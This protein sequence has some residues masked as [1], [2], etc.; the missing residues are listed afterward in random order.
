MPTTFKFINHACFTLTH[1]NHTIIFDPYLEGSTQDINDL[2]VEYIFVSHGHFDHLGSAIELAKN[3]DATIIST[4]EVCGVA[5]EAGAKAHAMHL[6]GTHEFP[7]GKVRLTLAF[8]GSGVPGGHAC[9]FIVD[10]YGTKLYFAGDTALFG[11]MQLLQRLDTFD[12]A[13]LP[14]GDNFT[15]GPKDAAIAAEFLQASYV[16]PIHYNTWPLI[17]QDPVKFKEDVEAHTKSKVL[18]VEPGA[19]IDRRTHV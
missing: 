15:M 12:Y 6:G 3:C 14:I 18:I 1:E 17:A 11:D 5:S 9:G 16:I 7:F 4:A 8:H 2:K 10:F 13:V 19:S